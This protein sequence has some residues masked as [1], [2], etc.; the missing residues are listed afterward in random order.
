MQFS[1][2]DITDGFDFT[3]SIAGAPR[4]LF[5][6]V[7][8][9]ARKGM[10]IGPCPAGC[11]LTMTRSGV[12][13][14]DNFSVPVPQ[15]A[16]GRFLLPENT[17]IGFSIKGGDGVGRT[18]ILLQNSDGVSLDR[19]TI[20]VKSTLRKRIFAVGMMDLKRETNRDENSARTVLS[21]ASAILTMQANV[22]LDVQGFARHLF[23]KVLGNPL[24]LDEHFPLI[25]K[26][27]LPLMQTVHVLVMFAWNVKND[28][29]DLRGGTRRDL[30]GNVFNYVFIEDS[31]P[32]ATLLHELGH[33]LLLE[34][35]MTDAQNFMITP[36]N[37]SRK[38]YRAA[39]IDKINTSG[40]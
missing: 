40:T 33:A 32:Q 31:A 5:Q 26:E 27:T 2:I 16:S 9:R 25:L 35:N 20:S 4:D 34:H 19:L 17:P 13:E 28:L 36:H 21:S 24:N 38:R 8:V 15:D 39:E 29:G 22:A 18:Q 10:S 23:P 30:S 7:P 3:A 11:S 37:D 6:M 14:I 1:K 12:V